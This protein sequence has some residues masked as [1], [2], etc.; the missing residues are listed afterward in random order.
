MKGTGAARLPM[1]SATSA[2]SSI[3]R[4]RPPSSSGTLMP[5]MPSSASPAQSL[6][7]WPPVS[8]SSSKSLCNAVVSMFSSR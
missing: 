3:S 2:R 6:A 1:V 8:L 4:P 5:R 7:S